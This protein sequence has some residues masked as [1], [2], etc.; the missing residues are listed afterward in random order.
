MSPYRESNPSLIHTTDACYRYHHKGVGLSGIE[1]A[2]ELDKNPE[3]HHSSLGL[4][5]V[6][7]A[8]LEPAILGLKVQS[9]SRLDTPPG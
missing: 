1:P 6:G 5:L 3:E 9:F 7:V 8:G 2:I 4:L